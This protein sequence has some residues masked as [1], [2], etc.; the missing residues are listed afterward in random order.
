[1]K[2]IR[3]LLIDIDDTIVQFRQGENSKARGDT[4]SLLSVGIGCSFTG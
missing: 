2:P 3:A 4:A 1:M